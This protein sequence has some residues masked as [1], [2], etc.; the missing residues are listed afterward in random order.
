[1]GEAEKKSM[2]LKLSQGKKIFVLGATI[3]LIALCV[4]SVFASLE[5]DDKS[6]LA[7]PTVKAG[8]NVLVKDDANYQVGKKYALSW[9]SDCRGGEVN[10]WLSTA[11][12]SKTNIGILVPLTGFSA[13]N[14]GE[15]D[16]DSRIFFSDPWKF[17][18]SHNNNKGKVSFVMPSS[19]NLPKNFFKSDQGV[20][21]TYITPDGRFALHKIVKEP[22]MM[23]VLPG[24]YYLRVD[25]KGKNGCLATGFSQKLLVSNDVFNAASKKK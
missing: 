16:S 9:D 12:S 3:T 10:V 13:A 19:L 2:I 20:F 25:I 7:S 22:V 4:Y 24:N 21:Y 23:Q 17:N 15:K 8:V 18:L 11:S 14:F 5:M 1:M 6:A